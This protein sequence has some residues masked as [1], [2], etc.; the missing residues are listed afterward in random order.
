MNPKDQLV[1]KLSVD[2]PQSGYLRGELVPIRIKVHHF[3]TIQCSAGLVVTLMRLCRV[4]NGPGAPIQSF[5]KDLCQTIAPLYINPETL[6]G[7]VSTSLRVPADAFPTIVGS[8]TVTF[9]Y[10]VEILANLSNKN[11]VRAGSGHT[12]VKGNQ[13]LSH[14]IVF[15]LDQQP[16]YTTSEEGMVNVDVLKRSKAFLGLNTEIIV[17]T[18]RVFKKKSTA[19][20]SSAA[21]SNGAVTGNGVI[22]PSV[23]DA[24]SQTS[25]SPISINGGSTANGAA[26]LNAATAAATAAITVP[27]PPP[28][29]DPIITGVGVEIPIPDTSQMSEKEAL[30][31]HEE[32]LLPSEPAYGSSPSSS[33]PAPSYVFASSSS[34]VYSAPPIVREE[35]PH[36]SDKAEMERRRLLAMESEPPEFDYV[37]EYPTPGSDGTATSSGMSTHIQHEQETL[38]G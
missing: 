4:D 29:S 11:I 30:R 3:K 21:K 10:Y 16:N 32:S 38:T 34:P 33:P 5:R 17:G 18:E 28:L 22:S 15:D 8:D 1:V 35:E 6:I 2:L 27:P 31:L 14:S 19:S 20:K 25:I 26:P 23:I 7:E 36:N 12:P 13:K 24:I 37:P 9:Q